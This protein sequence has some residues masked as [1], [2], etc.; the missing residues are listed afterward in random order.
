MNVAGRW[1]QRRGG[2]PSRLPHGRGAR[3]AT[4]DS[5]RG[6]DELMAPSL[7]RAEPE[8]QAGSTVVAAVPVRA[9]AK[10]QRRPACGQGND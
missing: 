5:A 1:R 9:Q 6:G 7:S 8:P 4:L 10:G 3:P 2:Q